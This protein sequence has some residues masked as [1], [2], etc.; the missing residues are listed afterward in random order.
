MP[1]CK[2]PVVPTAVQRARGMRSSAERSANGVKSAP[3]SAMR[4]AANVNGGRSRS[5]IR[6]TIQVEPH[7][8]QQVA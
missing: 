8:A 2:S 6:I 1:I 4:A 7:N 5:P 3:A